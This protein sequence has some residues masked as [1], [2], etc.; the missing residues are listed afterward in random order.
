MTRTITALTSHKT[1][2]NYNSPM[3][4]RTKNNQNT[5][6]EVAWTVP[7]FEAEVAWAERLGALD[8]VDEA[9]IVLDGFIIDSLRSVSIGPKTG[10]TLGKNCSAY[11]V[12][13]VQVVK[14][15]I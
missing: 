8:G 10:V 14:R 11:S 12:R 1:L 13:P 3:R 2:A 6:S 15:S 7:E 4:P 9:D 5:P